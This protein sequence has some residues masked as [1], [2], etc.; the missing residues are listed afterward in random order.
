RAFLR[1][2][3]PD[4]MLPSAFIIL[5][6]L[7]LTRNG[8]VDRQA[9]PAPDQERPDVQQVFVPPRTLTEEVLAS[10]WR[11]VLGLERVGIH[12]NFFE[13]GGHSLL[14]TQVMSRVREALQV[15]QPLRSLFE[16]PTV[17]QLAQRIEDSKSNSA[18]VWSPPIV[19]M[20]R[21]TVERRSSQESASSS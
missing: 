10:L 11:A 17:A 15:E 18:K 20:S 3:L 19:R 16:A 14:A 1:E 12:D 5:K 8:K 9:L 4:Y 13:L 2:K 21:E 7:P 6:S